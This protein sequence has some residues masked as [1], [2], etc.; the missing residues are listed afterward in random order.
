MKRVERISYPLFPT[1]EQ[2]KLMLLNCH[3]ARFAYNWG[4]AIIRKCLDEKTEIPSRY[5]IAKEFN[6]F[7]RTEG[8]EWLVSN[9]ASQRATKYAITKQLNTGMRM[10]NTQHKRPPSFHSKRNA[11]MTYYTD[12]ENIRFEPNYVLLEGL[13]LV[14]C[15]HNFDTFENVKIADPAVVFDG[16]NFT[17]SIAIVHKTPVKP[18]YHYSDVDIH[19][20]PIGIDIGIA[21]MAVTS[22]G[23]VFDVPELKSI[24]KQIARIDRRIDK[25]RRD[26]RGSYYENLSCDMKAKYP[27]EMVKSQNLLKLESRRRQLYQRHFNIRKDIR[28]KAVN[29][30]VKQ[31]PEAIVIEDIK[32]AKELWK[33]K[34]ANRY[35]KRLADVAV[36]DFIQRLKRKC[37]WLDIPIIEADKSYP[38]TKMCSCCGNT[39]ANTL[40]RDRMFIC[41]ECGYK[42][43]RDLNAAYTLRNIATKKVDKKKK[44]SKKIA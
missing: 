38:S 15:N 5:S 12:D 32:N 11:R 23:D 18:K 28:C 31:Y 8:Y 19:S 33:I 25:W 44:K 14:R 34:G 17:V 42:E 30:I 22:N 26:F 39:V 27:E 41:S 10:F 2:R 40:T 13:G 37:E 6:K 16:D 9:H 1:E 29:T 43:D 20:Q 4:V 21:H 36:G 7:K 35:N 24:D 3:N